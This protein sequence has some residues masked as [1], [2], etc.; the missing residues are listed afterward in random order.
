MRKYLRGLEGIVCREVDGEEKNSALIGAVR[1]SHDRRLKYK[2][3][4]P[5]GDT[6]QTL[7]EEN[8]LEGII[9]SHWHDIFNCHIHS[10]SK[11]FQ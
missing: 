7:G 10:A 11:I 6:D 2:K 5:D 3:K 4:L 1:R 9:S 8:F